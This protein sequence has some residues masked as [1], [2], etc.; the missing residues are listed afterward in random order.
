MFRF[1]DPQ[2]FVLMAVF[3]T[4]AYLFL[5][6]KG[7]K[8]SSIT[9]SDIRLVTT[10]ASRRRARMRHAIPVLRILAVAAMIVAFA[11]PQTG[12]TGEEILTDGIDIIMVMD[13]SGSM[14]AEDLEP[15]RLEAAKIVA[16]E[17]VGN[18]PNDRIGLVIFAGEAYT[19]APLT[20][21]HSI[22]Q[23]LLGELTTDMIG[24]QGTAIGMGIATAVKRL[25]GST[26]ES[27]VIVLVTDG[28]NNQGQIDPITAAQMAQ[29]LGIKIYSVGAGGHGLARIPIQDPVFGRRYQNIE[30]DIDEETLQ[31]TADLTNGRY[32]RATDTDSLASVYDEIDKLERTEIEVVNFT[33]YGELFHY[34]LFLGLAFLFLELVLGNTALR[35]VP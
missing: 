18:R 2:L 14:L 19:Q 24:V 31:E 9:F 6:R 15:N 27:K 34:P 17:F 13:V 33:R 23:S 10:S 35:K 3:T 12:I 16:A 8:E 32:F 30:V 29:A 21:D 22:I 28:R 26:A 20:L 1:A 7:H 25:E 5:L 11:R 4:I